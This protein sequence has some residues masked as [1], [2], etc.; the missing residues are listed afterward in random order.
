ML[1]TCVA[2]YFFSFLEI[3]ITATPQ[4]VKDVYFDHNLF[5]HYIRISDAIRHIF[6]SI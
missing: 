3:E 2:A 5:I 4:C 1:L 6:F